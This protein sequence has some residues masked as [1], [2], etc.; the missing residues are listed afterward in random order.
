MG[1]EISEEMSGSILDVSEAEAWYGAIGQSPS[2][3]SG[4]VEEAVLQLVVE[5]VAD[6]QATC[7]S[8]PLLWWVGILVQSSLQAGADDYISRGRFNL[9]IL[10]MDLD[11]RARLE[12]LLHYSKVLV[13]DHTMH[14]WKTSKSRMMEVRGDM[15]AVNNEWLNADDDRRP[16]AIVDNRNCS[17]VAWKDML[18]HLQSQCNIYLGKQPGMAVRQFR[19][20][21]EE[22]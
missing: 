16:E 12:G 5:F 6:R 4:P 13:L 8:N 14:S 22:N 2:R 10:P 20:L 9:N 15:A 19:L 7:T 18:K 11:I 1:L 21:L 3:Q 17:S